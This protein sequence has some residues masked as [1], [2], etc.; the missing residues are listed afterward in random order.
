M[1][2]RIS[3]CRLTG[4]GGK[5]VYTGTVWPPGS[6]A[7]SAASTGD[8]FGGASAAVVAASSS[9]AGAGAAAAR[10]KGLEG[11]G[12]AIGKA[13]ADGVDGADTGLVKVCRTCTQRAGCSR[14]PGPGARGSR[15]SKTACSNSTR[16]ASSHAPRRRAGL[17]SGATLVK[18]KGICAAVVTPQ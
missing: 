8:G 10:A 9:L 7:G 13:V 2:R 6:G 18:A 3:N 16:P 4:G 17:S 14:Q 1:P 11:V 12:D 15:P 5:V